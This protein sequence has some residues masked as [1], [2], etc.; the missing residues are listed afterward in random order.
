MLEV[1]M[2]YRFMRIGLVM[3]LV[4][5]AFS[6]SAQTNAIASTNRAGEVLK[7]GQAPIRDA[8]K[9]T[10]S[11]VPNQSTVA[12]E[13]V[14][15]IEERSEQIRTAC[16]NGRRYVCGKVLQIVPEGIVVDSGFSVL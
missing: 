2:K 4:S 12:K 14:L 1:A 6:G 3:L 15:S 7:D 10:E 9:I 13:K 16:I 5:A 11:A 8:Q